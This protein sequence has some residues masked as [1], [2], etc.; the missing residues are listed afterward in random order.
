MA[1]YQLGDDIPLV[2]ASAYVAEEAVVIGK[3][4]LGKHA[5]IWPGAVIRADNDTIRIGDNSNVQDGSVLHADP[6][7][8]LKIGN[9]VTVG[10]LVMLHGCT[11]GDGSLI[12]IQ[13]VVMNGAVIGEDCLVGAG[14][15]VTEGK[16][17]PPRKLILG[18]PAHTMRDLKDDDIQMLHR[19]NASYIR[20][21]EI[22]RN[23]LK[24][25]G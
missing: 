17:F 22:Y 19:A 13:S 16:K 12:G 1:I 11:V 10:H 18:A 21:Q 25:L 6:G 20:R 23:K 2:P 3:V 9:N 7:F 5:S 24:R 4:T 15:I 8:P 14:A